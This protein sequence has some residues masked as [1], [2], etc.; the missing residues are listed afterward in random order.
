MSCRWNFLNCRRFDLLTPGLARLACTVLN[1]A[2]ETVG[3]EGALNV[4]SAVEVT[5]KG[6][7]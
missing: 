3:A 5:C 4:S 2:S 7:L 1:L 6:D